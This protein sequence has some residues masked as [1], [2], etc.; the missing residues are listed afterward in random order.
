VSVAKQTR[1]VFNGL[2]ADSLP[3]AAE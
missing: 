2:A 1:K 3:T